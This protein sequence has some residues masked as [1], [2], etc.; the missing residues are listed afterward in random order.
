MCGREGRAKVGGR[1][2]AGVRECGKVIE[3]RSRGSGAA[4]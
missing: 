2:G 4:V 3:G 1:A